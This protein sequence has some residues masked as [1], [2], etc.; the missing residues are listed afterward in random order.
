MITLKEEE[1]AKMSEE[2]MKAI[3]K[4]KQRGIILKVKN[5]LVEEDCPCLRRDEPVGFFQY[6][7]AKR[8]Y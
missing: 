1:I 7:Y 4:K 5:L 6:R 8:V 2:E 3:G